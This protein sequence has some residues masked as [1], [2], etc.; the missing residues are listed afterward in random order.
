MV[1]PLLVDGHIKEWTVGQYH[2]VTDRTFVVRRASRINDALPS[3]SSDRWIWESGPWLLV[4]RISGHVA[5]LHL[6]DYN[7]A[8]SEVIWF[9]DYAAY[10]GVNASGR[11]LYAVVFQIA[12]RKAAITKELKD[13]A[14]IQV[15]KQACPEISWQRDPLRVIFRE[16]SGEERSFNVV[17]NLAVQMGDAEEDDSKD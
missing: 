3:E 8:V 6:P 13:W 17:G 2:D 7:P 1:R 16:V 10:C 12:A 5:V 14:P 9:R 4:D 11:S 15:G